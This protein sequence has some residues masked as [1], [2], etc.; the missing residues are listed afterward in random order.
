MLINDQEPYFPMSRKELRRQIKQHRMFENCVYINPN[1]NYRKSQVMYNQ[2]YAY[3]GFI[4]C[5]GSI[6]DSVNSGGKKNVELLSSLSNPKISTK[7]AAGGTTVG[8]ISRAKSSGG[9]RFKKRAQHV[10]NQYLIDKV[11]EGRSELAKSKL[12]V[13][14]Q[15]QSV[16]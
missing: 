7:S 4:E 9:Y 3:P 1:Y 6:Y 10:S 8:P 11:K 13:K 12:N 15:S 16:H 14:N 2:K 5:G